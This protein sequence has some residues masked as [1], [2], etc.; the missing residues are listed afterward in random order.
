MK[1]RSAPRGTP[2]A[3]ITQLESAIRN[4]VGSVEFVKGSENLGVRPAFMSAD[5]F[6]ALIA[7]E[8][9]ELARLMQSI[10]LKK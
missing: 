7:K 6:G 5:E 4:T 3:V 9:A 2:R 10:G 8:D 1:C